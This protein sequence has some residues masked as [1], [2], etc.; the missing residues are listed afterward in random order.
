MEPVPVSTPSPVTPATG[1][2]AA[3]DALLHGRALGPED[4]GFDDARFGFNRIVDRRP[5]VIASCADAA[6]VRAAV[7]FASERGLEIAVRGGGHSMAG[8]STVE[9]GLV[10]DLSSLRYVRVDP[11]AR[12]AAVGGGATAGDLDHATSAFGLATPGATVSSVGMAGFT[13]GGGI[14]Y[15]NRAHGLALDNLLGADVVLADGS[16]VRADAEHEPELFWALR[17]GGGNFGVVTELRY[18]LHPVSAVTGGPMLWP[19]ED[20]ARVMRCFREW[21]P[22]QPRDIYAFLLFLTAPPVDPFPEALRGRPA[23]ALMWCNLAP[24]ERSRAALDA[25]RAE[26]PPALDLV[27]ELPYPALQRAS[28]E[29]A[30]LGD[31]LVSTGNLFRT[32]PDDAADTCARFQASAPTPQCMTHLYPLDGATA[33]VPAG[34]TAWAWR[35]ASVAQLVV[36]AGDAPA[37]DAAVGVWARDFAAALEPAAL[38]GA[39]TNFL[40]DD[41]EAQARRCYGEHYGRL[42]VVKAGYDPHDRFHRNHAIAPAV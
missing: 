30:A 16:L 41:G 1:R 19:V 12:T 42:A 3:L 2:A 22:A 11:E 34:A 5:A 13:L 28:D 40:S 15:L 32:L 14:G 26:V 31:R 27:A 37:H 20:A 18:R 23:C 25:V 29:D 6:D 39:Y 10:I 9:G 8:F 24:P 21:L 38:R 35:D 7:A 17:G 33:D 4:D 36:G